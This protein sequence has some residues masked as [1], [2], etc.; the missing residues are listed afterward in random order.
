[1]KRW[2]VRYEQNGG[3]YSSTLVIEAKVVK[4]TGPRSIKVDGINIQLDEDIEKVEQFDWSG[5]KTGA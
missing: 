5:P 1:M 4:Q 2:L 3:E